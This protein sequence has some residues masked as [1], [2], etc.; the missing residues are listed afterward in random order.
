[1]VNDFC[2]QARKAENTDPRTNYAVKYATAR[3]RLRM[4]KFD[5]TATRCADT[6]LATIAARNL[7]VL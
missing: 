1:M 3:D 6:A 2:C 5:D 7:V 4:I